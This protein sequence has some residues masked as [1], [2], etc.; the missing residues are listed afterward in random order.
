MYS[1]PIIIIFQPICRMN[2][3]CTNNNKSKQQ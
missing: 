2:F 1:D 3:H